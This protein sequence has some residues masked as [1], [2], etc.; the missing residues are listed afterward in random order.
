MM[1][2]LFAGSTPIRSDAF[3]GSAEQV[4]ALRPASAEQADAAGA[5]AQ[6]RSCDT[7]HLR[8]QL[9]G[10]LN[11]IVLK[12]LEKD[13]SQ[14]YETVA[15]LAATCRGSLTMRPCSRARPRRST[16]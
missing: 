15:A 7:E 11:W 4:T 9:R 2:E 1:Y 14:R 16:G 12:C 5:I 3:K 13:Q 6:K 8:Q 10:D